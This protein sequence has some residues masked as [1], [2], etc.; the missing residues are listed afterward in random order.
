MSTTHLSPV[1][2]GDV[3]VAM[4]GRQE[5]L[6]KVTCS[7]QPSSLGRG[8]VAAYRPTGWGVAN[9]SIRLL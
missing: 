1:E 8:R 5:D 2:K 9:P 6:L 7:W 3:D 4:I